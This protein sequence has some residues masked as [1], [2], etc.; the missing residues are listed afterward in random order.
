MAGWTMMMTVLTEVYD[1]MLEEHA[2]PDP[3][4]GEVV[5]RS[6]RAVF[7]RVCE[8]MDT[9]ADMTELESFREAMSG[10]LTIVGAIADEPLADEYT[11][12]TALLYIIRQ[13][14]LFGERTANDDLRRRVFELESGIDLIRKWIKKELPEDGKIM[15]DIIDAVVSGV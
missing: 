14:R 4:T 5:D 1:W 2:E 15:L 10:A 13:S 8:A 12:S 9:E 11:P 7:E 3:S 6:A